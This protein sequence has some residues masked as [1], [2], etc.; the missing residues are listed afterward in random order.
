M[1]NSLTRFLKKK[2]KSK[3]YKLINIFKETLII[4]VEFIVKLNLKQNLELEKNMYI[5]F[6]MHFFY[7]GYVICM[8]SFFK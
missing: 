3:N 7:A 4:F 8:L 6:T 1:K 5:I 2:L